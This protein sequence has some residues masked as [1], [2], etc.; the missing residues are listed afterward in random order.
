[1]KKQLILLAILTSLIVPS[2]SNAILV[3][4]NNNNYDSVGKSFG[5]GLCEGYF[6][7][8]AQAEA[9]NRKIIETRNKIYAYEMIR[10]YNPEY[11]DEFVSCI[12]KSALEEHEKMLIIANFNERQQDWINSQ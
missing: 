4:P 11:H 6:Q 5:E 2:I 7:G 10:D 12:S 9:K 1:M 3:V 8:R